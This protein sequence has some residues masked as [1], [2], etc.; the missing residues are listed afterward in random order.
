MQIDSDWKAQLV[1][2]TPPEELPAITDQTAVTGN[3]TK[4]VSA[5]ITDVPMNNGKPSFANL[6]HERNNWL[7]LAGPKDESTNEEINQ[8]LQ[9]ALAAKCKPIVCFSD[10]DSTQLSSR[11]A[12][13]SPADLAK[14]V[15]AYASPEPCT[16]DQASQAASQVE[17]TLKLK[18]T[19]PDSPKLIVHSQPTGESAAQLA[20]TP[21][22]SGV[23]LPAS[24]AID[25]SC[26][27][28][29]LAE[30]DQAQ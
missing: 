26:I 23:F 24:D 30:L 18:L 28:E 29:V 22:I 16:P 21:G 3:D 15:I 14:I 27:L 5:G 17:S 25:F 13:L 19:A 6:Q 7:L 1:L 12:G 8:K 10:L 4:I 2:L 9:A 20:A 11:F